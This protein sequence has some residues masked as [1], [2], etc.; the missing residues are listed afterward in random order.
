MKLKHKNDEQI[1]PVNGLKIRRLSGLENFV[2]DNVVFNS[3]RNFKPV[4]R[5][6]NRSDVLEFQL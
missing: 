1:D 5:F 6:Q 3:F 2:R 4:K